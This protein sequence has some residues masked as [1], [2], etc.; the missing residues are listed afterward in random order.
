MEEQAASTHRTARDELRVETEPAGPDQHAID[1]LVRELADHPDVSEHLAETQHRLLGFALIDSEDK[2]DQPQASDR[3]HATYYDYTNGRSVLV[4]GSLADR[5]HVAVTSSSGQPLPSPE[6]FAA[7]LDILAGDPEFGP[8]ISDG[9]LQPYESMPPVIEAELP[10]G[11][12]E[13][14]LTVG[15][16]PTTGRGGSYHEI[17]G[18]NMVRQ[19]V[20]RYDNN[21][22]PSSRATR[23][24]CGTPPSA[25][26]AT[27]G[28]GV[29]GQVWITVVQGGTVLWRFLAVRPSASSG[30]WGSGVELRH[31]S[32][33]GRSVLYQAHVPILN[34]L[35]DAN[36][37]GPYRD[38]QYQ[39][40]ML[41]ANGTNVAPGFVLCP[42]PARTILD[43]GSDVGNFLGVAIY[44]VGQEV[45]L[46]SEMQ[47]G[48]YR[49]VSEWRLHANGTIRPRFGF[50]A[51]SSS[52]VCNRH[53]HHVYWRLD[54]DIES[55]GNNL[56]R[57]F[58]DPPIF[59]G[60]NWHTKQYEIMRLRSQPH[61]RRWR[62]ENAGSNRGYT[63][64]PG[65]NDGT[66]AGD[67]YAR[68]DVWFLRHHPGEI[69]DHPIIGTEIQIDK[70]RNGEPLV[71][72]D[73]VVWYGA[74]FTH[75]VSGPPV[76]HVVGPALTPHAW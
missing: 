2:V 71:N 52:C 15:L 47:A 10:D 42:T 21:A 61:H 29:P 62:V 58:N 66:A 64:T 3:Y 20:E 8:A 31:V 46:V 74:H 11:R 68:G 69:D 24:T 19:T 22:P 13:R 51:T 39:E 14:T 72:Q 26:Q 36:A 12:T 48:W 33:R 18:V 37:C 34:V 25:G 65:V 28:K 44:V 32:Y 49:Y 75:D 41:Q 23:G 53:H 67:P 7:A 9:A 1:A 57:E 27:T 43:T 4:E 54:F 6:E 60:M 70:Y 16:L 30:Y 38:W 45:V 40:G 17:V 56:V 50:D 55:A 59:P 35:Y 63:I 76:N 5:E 73:V